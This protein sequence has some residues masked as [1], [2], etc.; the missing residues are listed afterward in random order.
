MSIDSGRCEHCGQVLPEARKQKRKE[1][2]RKIKKRVKRSTKFVLEQVDNFIGR[3]G[4]DP[5]QILVLDGV[6]DTRADQL[7]LQ[8]MY[9]EAIGERYCS[10]QLGRALDLEPNEFSS[11]ISDLKSEDDEVEAL[12]QETDEEYWTTKGNACAE[13]EIAIDLEEKDF[14]G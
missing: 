6:A 7:F 4:R 11:T 8:A 13:L 14:N 9:F 1:R 3:W 10:D 12:L 5:D 2:R